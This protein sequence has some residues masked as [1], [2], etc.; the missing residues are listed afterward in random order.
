MLPQEE[1][2]RLVSEEMA[3]LGRF[4]DPLKCRVVIQAAGETGFDASVVV[5]SRALSS[6]RTA[7]RSAHPRAGRSMSC[8]SKTTSP[9]S[10]R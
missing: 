7:A 8:S 5:G 3:E 9:R 10:A 6:L 4:S 2:L 1:I